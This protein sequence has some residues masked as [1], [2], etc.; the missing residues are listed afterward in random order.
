MFTH[1]AARVPE[2]ERT[3]SR[4]RSALEWSPERVERLKHY[5]KVDGLSASKIAKELGFTTR[6]AVLGKLHR[7][8]LLGTVGPR[9][10]KTP[11]IIAERRQQRLARMRQYNKENRPKLN[12]YKRAWNA[13]NPDKV[14]ARRQRPPRPKA[15]YQAR[16]KA[17]RDNRI[18]DL[19]MTPL[20]TPRDMQISLA[21]ISTDQCRWP[22]EGQMF[23]G[24]QTKDNR[25]YCPHHHAR[26]YL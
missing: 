22:Y 4:F 25:S 11:E 12:A 8:G 26:A 21:D 1:N 9:V 15:I 18:I 24:K 19:R 23:C 10:L 13:A 17:D 6:N 2:N 5:W 16:V 14:K 3:T 7:L 20:D